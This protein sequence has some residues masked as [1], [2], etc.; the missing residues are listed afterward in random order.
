MAQP[1]SQQIALEATPYYHCIS[2]CVRRAFLCGFDRLTNKSYEHR[3]DLIE[4]RL[5]LLAEVFCIDLVAYAVLSNHYH[6]VLHIN[7]EKALNLSFDDVIERWHR[8]FKGT[9]QSQLYAS[10]IPLSRADKL[11]LHR[12]VNLWRNRLH[13]ISWFMRCSN[14]PIARQANKE[15]G[16]KGRFFESRFISQALLDDAAVLACACYVDLNPNRA[17]IADTPEESD[18]TS[19][20]QRLS[21]YKDNKRSIGLFPFAGNPREPMPEGIPCTA[22]DYFELI[23]M[24]AREH[25]HGSTGY[26]DNNLSPILDRL[27]IPTSNWLKASAEFESVFSIFVGKKHS[28]LKACEVFSKKWV[29]LQSQCWQILSG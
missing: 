12:S 26:M 17:G 4:K 28:L 25:R 7:Q 16:C 8:L 14:E 22:E 5:Y 27:G 11:I 9:Y 15:D 18:F 6:V 19:I 21:S 24:T 3:R 23:D 1:R 13:D 20:K 10:G 29:N 2:R